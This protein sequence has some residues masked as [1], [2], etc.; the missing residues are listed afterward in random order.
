MP[1]PNV[2]RNPLPESG[3]KI[4]LHVVVAAAAAMPGDSVETGC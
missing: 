1:F 3:P 4:V 2:H